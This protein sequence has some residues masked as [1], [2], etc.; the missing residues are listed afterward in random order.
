MN[1][2]N[3]NIPKDKSLFYWL[4]VKSTTTNV[5]YPVPC[6]YSEK[7]GGW[8]SFD[9]EKLSSHSVVSY[10]P[11]LKPKPYGIVGSGVG[12][13]IRTDVGNAN[14]SIYG[15]G[16]QPANWVMKGYSTKE[17]AISATNRL[18]KID[19]GDGRERCNYQVINGVGEVIWNSQ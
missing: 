2:S 15:F 7:D 19:I 13:Y 5:T 17:K 9:G 14:E 4:T 18:K 16:L 12:Y 1:W 11:I 3:G 10:C 6:R 8:K